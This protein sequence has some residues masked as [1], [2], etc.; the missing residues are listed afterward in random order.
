MKKRIS[1]NRKTFFE[2]YPGCKVRSYVFAQLAIV[3]VSQNSMTPKLRLLFLVTYA[4]CL[5][6]FCSHRIQEDDKS[7]DLQ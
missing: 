3:T 7:T 5:L 1:Y 6:I 4:T 2:T